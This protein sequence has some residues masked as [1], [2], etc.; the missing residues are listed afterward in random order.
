[1]GAPA[2]DRQ[3]AGLNSYNILSPR[4]FSLYNLNIEAHLGTW[5][6]IPLEGRGPPSCPG[7]RLPCLW[8]MYVGRSREWVGQLLVL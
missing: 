7:S 8:E 5:K 6:G 4:Q 3:V 1:M 2:C